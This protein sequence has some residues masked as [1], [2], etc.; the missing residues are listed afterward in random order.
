[1]LATNGT[2]TQITWDGAHPA[3]GFSTMFGGKGVNV[4]NG[5]ALDPAGNVY[6]VGSA[7][8]TNF[9][10]TTNN[11]SG[12]LSATNSSQK[13]KNYS[14]AFIMAFNT[15]ATALLYSAYLGGRE[16]DYGNAIAVDPVGNAYIVGQTLSTNFPAVNARQTFR[17]GTNDMFIAK[18]SQATNAPVL[19]ILPQSSTPPGVSL[20]WRMFP[21]AYG[22]ESATD[23]GV[24][25]WSVI[26]QAP[27]G[28]N[29]WY[30]I[31]LP[32]TNT[33]EFFRLRQ[34]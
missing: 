17:N 34:N 5:V 7:T 27:T 1:V 20:N 2:L 24:G 6:V 19:T 31:T 25:N 22:V 16:R 30:Q 3:I 33:A 13:S 28:S 15:N 9:P 14:D 26:P 23:L 29:G 32:A 12:Y 10:V 4:A 21:P 11:I 18:I 8:C